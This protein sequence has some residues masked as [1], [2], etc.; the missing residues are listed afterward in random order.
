VNVVK[1]L[2]VI[3]LSLKLRGAWADGDGAQQEERALKKDMVEG[4][5]DN[6]FKVHADQEYA[7]SVD[8]KRFNR[9]KVNIERSYDWILAYICVELIVNIVLLNDR[10]VILK[11]MRRYSPKQRAKVGG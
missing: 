2:P 10:E 9:F 1:R 6:W 5:H 7:L 4:R 11:R 8:L 3:N